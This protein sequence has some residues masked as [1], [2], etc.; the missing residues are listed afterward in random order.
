MCLLCD[1]VADRSLASRHQIGHQ[2]RL[3]SAYI[4][5]QY[6]IDQDSAD[7]TRRITATDFVL[8]YY[9]HITGGAVQVSGGDFGAQIIRSLEIPPAD[10][11]F[12]RST[13][14]RLDSLI[15]LEFSRGV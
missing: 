9:M 6:L 7:F 4:E 10:H 11:A 8:D 13:I 2:A 14:D 12:F 5:T 3:G 1:Q 15:D